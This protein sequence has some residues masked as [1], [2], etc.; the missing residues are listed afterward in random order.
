MNEYRYIGVSLSGKP[1]QGKIY[2]ENSTEL[3]DKLST[4]SDKHKIDIKK[5]Q[6]KQTYIYKVKNDSDKIIYGDQKAFSAGEVRRA[7][8]NMGFHIFY[9]RK[10]IFDLKPRVPSQDI[11]NFIQLSAD[12]LK[13]KFTYDEILQLLSNDIENTTLKQTVKEIYQDLKKGKEGFHVYGKH[14]NVFG[15]FTSYMLSIASTSGN[16]REIYESTAKY[17]TRDANFRKNL[18][19]ALF[20]PLVIFAAI[21][22]TFIFYIAYIFPQMTDMLIKQNVKIPSMTQKCIYLSEFFKNELIWVIIGAAIP[23][24]F[25]IK[26]INS[27]DGKIIY[28]R[29]IIKLPII[30]S[31]F[32]KSSIE[33]FSRVFYTLYSSSGQN[34]NVIKTAAEACRNVYIEKKIKK[35]VI[36]TMLSEG[37]SFTESVEKTGVFPVNAINRFRTGEESGTL[38]ESLQQLANYY[39]NETAHKIAQVINYVNL[40]TSIIVSLLIIILTLISTEIGFISPTNI[41]R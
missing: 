20:M 1:I 17:L 3:K 36:P 14:I 4:I 12:L 33:I 19:S 27:P 18:R 6:K 16:M 40:S 8:T 24:A 21:I 29:L 41:V 39:E 15:K 34:I 10:K 5:F 7:L 2:T 35:I 9:V 26:Y 11:V 28:H 23:L 31:L 30:G 37:K 38:K 22:A 25:I 13:E 32:H